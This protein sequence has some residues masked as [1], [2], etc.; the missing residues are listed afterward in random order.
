MARPQ[1]H[2]RSQP[3]SFTRRTL[4]ST[5][6]FIA[7]IALALIGTGTSYALW[8]VKAMV[9]ASA[10][11]SG[12]ASLTVTSPTGM[13]VSA[14]SPGQ[15]VVAAVTLTNI[16]SS[17]LNANVT[18]TTVV[19]NDLSDSLT[20]HLTP[21]ATCSAGLSGGVTAAMNGFTTPSTTPYDLPVGTS[22]QLCLEIKLLASAPVT[23]QNLSASPVATFTA[24][25]V[26]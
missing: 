4:A 1:R 7:A 3:A 8:N 5:G 15:S 2:V 14:L 10:V 26:R 16:G 6:I 23:A 17:H 25:Q 22:V 18:S 24:T 13:D 9:N 19:K 12:T 11:T 21:S 20:I